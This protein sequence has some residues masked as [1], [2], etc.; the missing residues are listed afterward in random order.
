MIRDLFKDLTKYLPAH[1][2]PGLV[3]IIS[4]PIITRLI[5]P[6]EYGNY[7]IVLATITFFSSIASAWL[8]ASSIRFYPSY[9]QDN[10]LEKFYS[11]I[12]KLVFI[13]VISLSFISLIILFFIKNSI[14]VSLYSLMYIG[15]LV[16]IVSSI[17][18][19][20]NSI[21]RAKRK[22]SWYSFS[23]IWHY[24]IKFIL[25]IILIIVF[26]LG[27][28]GLLLGSFISIVIILPLLYNLAIGKISLKKGKV[29]S[30]MTLS[31]IKYGFPVIIIN[32]ASW[33]VMFSDRY[34]LNFFL[35]S[36]IVG[37]YSVGYIIPERSIF[38]I[39]ALISMAA[40]PI[41]F[42]IW[43]QQGVKA[44]QDF[45]T[46]LTRYYLL[47]GLPM[48]VGLSVLSKPVMHIF[49]DPLYFSG[50]KVIPLIAFSMF[51]IGITNRFNMVVSFYKKTS[52]IMFCNLFG[53]VLNIG[54]NLWL[55]PKYGYMAA[56]LTTFI[57][58][59][60]QIVIMVVISRHFLTWR[61]P[62]KSL[63][64][65]VIASLVMGI[66]VYYSSNYLAALNLLN[67]IIAIC[68]GAV[69]YFAMILLFNEFQVK[70][71]NAARTLVF[72]IFKSK[73]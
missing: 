39:V 48:T 61:F 30:S 19:V 8:S 38:F 24:V 13:I 53:G 45:L 52:L 29:F 2:I 71:I 20:F 21:L 60:V 12:I 23:Q 65:I 14:S 47:I 22:A 34:L 10:C 31:M 73:R 62:F 26:H 49:A 63:G 25:G 56:A 37:I 35:G 5:S 44:S 4:I 11:V 64:K 9:K 40:N 7:V 42:R 43:E 33:I 50:Y 6:E 17:Y 58:F 72:K 46:K 57:T 32:L 3:G 66:V 36:K 41:A 28:R 55:I 54:L 68:V 27:A 70:E 16:F 59:A 51:F 69:V 15:L 67:L 18:D 1:V